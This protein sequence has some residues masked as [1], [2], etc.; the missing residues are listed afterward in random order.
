MFVYVSRKQMVD[1]KQTSIILFLPQNK[2][3]LFCKFILKACLYKQI[4]KNKSDIFDRIE[5]WYYVVDGLL[6]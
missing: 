3:G 1:G 4:T 6:L 2:V 5:I